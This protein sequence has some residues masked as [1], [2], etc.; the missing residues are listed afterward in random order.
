VLGVLGSGRVWV[1][2]ENEI[3]CVEDI[4][5]KAQWVKDHML[6]GKRWISTENGGPDSRCPGTPI[7]WTQDPA[8]FELWRTAVQGPTSDMGNYATPPARKRS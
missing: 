5:A 1:Q 4:P 7:S 8:L 6:A 2:C 3:G